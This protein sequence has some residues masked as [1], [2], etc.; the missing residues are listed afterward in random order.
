MQCEQIYLQDFPVPQYKGLGSYVR[1]TTTLQSLQ[2]S[3][4]NYR[5]KHLFL[6]PAPFCPCVAYYDKIFL[7]HDNPTLPT[8]GIPQNKVKSHCKTLQLYLFTSTHRTLHISPRWVPIPCEYW[9]TG[10]FSHLPCLDTWG[11][12]SSVCRYYD[13]CPASRG[14]EVVLRGCWHHP[15][16]HI[17]YTAT[18]SSI[19]TVTNNPEKFCV[20]VRFLPRNRIQNNHQDENNNNY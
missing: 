17:T 8:R 6:E 11:A 18:G 2:E 10:L 7:S 1:E 15:L 5:A 16:V 20:N 14:T 9:H 3:N 13:V 12:P 19:N 4:L